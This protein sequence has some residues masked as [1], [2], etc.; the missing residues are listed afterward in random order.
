MQADIRKLVKDCYPRLYD[1]DIDLYIAECERRGVDPLSRL[2]VP[3]PNN[4]KDR[5][6]TWRRGGPPAWITTIDLMRARADETGT[7]APGKETVF[8]YGTGDVPQRATAYAKKFVQGQWIEFSESARWVEFYPGDGPDGAMWRKMQEVMLG[9]TA[10]ARTLR[11]GWPAQLA[12]LYEGSEL[13]QSRDHAEQETAPNAA[14]RIAAASNHNAIAPTS[15]DPHAGEPP[16]ARYEKALAAVAEAKTPKNVAAIAAKADKLHDEKVFSDG[17]HE[18]LKTYTGLLSRMMN[19]KTLGEI[20]AVETSVDAAVDAGAVTRDQGD[21][22]NHFGI[23][24]RRTI[25][26]Q[27]AL[28]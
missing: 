21:K 25:E 7:Y 14:S 27:E 1:E 24:Q 22:V 26:Q 10:E 3:R 12:G 19:A 16:E 6:G 17:Q 28:V 2:I 18:R 4:K 11:R 15:T 8:E 20:N 9:K 23:S 13:D 5:D